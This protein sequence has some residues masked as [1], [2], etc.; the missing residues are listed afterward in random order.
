MYKWT[1]TLSGVKVQF[2]TENKHSTIRTSHSWDK[3]AGLAMIGSWMSG[4]KAKAGKK[5]T[6][7]QQWKK[8]VFVSFGK[9]AQC[10]ES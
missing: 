7:L 3:Q 8:S 9:A 1:L 2:R 10:G 4:R 5:K 6:V